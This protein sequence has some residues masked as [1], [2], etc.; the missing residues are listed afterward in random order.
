MAVEKSNILKQL[1]QSEKIYVILSQFTRMPFVVCDPETYNDGIFLYFKEEDAKEKEKELMATG[2]SVTVAGIEKKGFLAFYSSLYPM[3]VDGLMVDFGLES[4]MFIML[5]ELVRRPDPSQLPEGKKIIEN[6][7]LHLTALYFMQEFRKEKR[8][9]LDAS[10]QGMQEEMMAHYKDGTYLIALKADGTGVVFMKNAN[11]TTLLPIFTD[12][13]EFHK[14]QLMN[15]NEKFGT[16]VVLAEKISG[17]L[18]PEA[19]TIVINP[20]TTNIPLN[21]ERKKQ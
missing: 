11:G 1:Q 12:A 5:N 4:G 14:F 13:G 6:P 21:V 8:T 18:P 10:L 17:L 20:M 19:S 16:G 3:G 7:S 2:N 15:P 9:Q